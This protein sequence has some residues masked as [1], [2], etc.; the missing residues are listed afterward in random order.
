MACRHS[1][2]ASRG[3]TP[4]VLVKRG[5]RSPVFARISR[6]ES[7]NRLVPATDGAWRATSYRVIR[8]RKRSEHHTVSRVANCRASLPGTSPT[9]LF[10]TNQMVVCVSPN[11][12]R[13]CRVA[14]GA[15]SAAHYVV[16]CGE[17]WG[18]TMPANRPTAPFAGLIP[19][20]ERSL[21]RN[22]RTPPVPHMNRAW[23]SDAPCY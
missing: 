19:T 2:A 23:D 15:F 20:E 9:L 16:V 17:C 14:H 7:P 22:F 5:T 13:S 18:L 11:M 3:T 12:P 6:L 10:R 21:R 8:S 4:E 1:Q